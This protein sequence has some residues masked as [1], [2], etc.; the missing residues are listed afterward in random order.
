MVWTIFNTETIASKCLTLWSRF[1]T[2]TRKEVDHQKTIQCCYIEYVEDVKQDEQIV[3]DLV[4]SIIRPTCHDIAELRM[5]WMKMHQGPK[6][7]KT[8][9][10]L[11]DV[12]KNH[13][14][15]LE[16]ACRSKAG[17]L[18]SIFVTNWQIPAPK[19]SKI[20]DWAPAGLFQ[21]FKTCF[22]LVGNKDY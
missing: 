21:I 1:W 13:G 22:L 3:P 7:K 15:P 16:A 20:W 11:L 18:Q 8:G 14:F 19:N 5:I 4:D 17:H 10:S 6:S 12:W 9:F 2:H